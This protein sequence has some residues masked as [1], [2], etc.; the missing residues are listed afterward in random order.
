MC[1]HV[2]VC[3]M[4]KCDVSSR[5]TYIGWLLSMIIT[6]FKASSHSQISSTILCSLHSVSSLPPVACIKISC[7][8]PA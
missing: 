1:N 8:F 2:C 3:I 7:S 6:S 4:L 5:C